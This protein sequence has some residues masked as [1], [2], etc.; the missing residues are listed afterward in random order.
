[1]LDSRVT[2]I[3][4]VLLSL[5]TERAIADMVGPDYDAP[6]QVDIDHVS[7]QIENLGIA[8]ENGS[9]RAFSEPDIDQLTC[10]AVVEALEDET[11]TMNSASVPFAWEWNPPT[12]RESAQ[13]T[14]RYAG[15]CFIYS[16]LSP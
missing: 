2:L 8:H 16:I 9:L 7:T 15:T 10:L 11:Y 12:P 6:I 3:V 4:C 5:T 13:H 1:M 14:G